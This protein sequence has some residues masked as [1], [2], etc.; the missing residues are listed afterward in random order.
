MTWRSRLFSLF[1]ALFVLGALAAVAW[2][3]VAPGWIPAAWLLFHLYG[4]PL[5]CYRLHQ[6]CWPIEEGVCRLDL[7]GVYVPWWGGHMFQLPYDALPELEALLRLVPGLYSLWLRGWGARIGRAVYW[8]PR[9]EITDRAMLDIGDHAVLGH[10][11]GFYAHVV[12]RKESGELRLLVR[13]IRIGRG[14]LI[15]AYSRF[16]PGANVAAG[17]HLPVCTDLWAGGG[18]PSQNP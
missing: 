15:G 3:L 9:I 2:L 16:G 14:A 1:P 18:V 17:A 7:P 13:R 6:L 5:A 4:L 8:T 12:A 10:R 11:S